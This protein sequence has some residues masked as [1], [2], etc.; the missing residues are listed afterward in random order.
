MSKDDSNW[1]MELGGMSKWAEPLIPEKI[2]EAFEEEE[3][4][5]AFEAEPNSFFD[6]HA[7]KI[8]TTFLF[9]GWVTFHFVEGYTWGQSWYFVCVTLTTVGYGDVSPSTHLG[10]ILAV[11]YIIVGLAFV[12]ESI[13]S[14]ASAIATWKAESERVKAADAEKKEAKRMKRMMSVGAMKHKK[15]R[16]KDII[17]DDSQAKILRAVGLLLLCVFI[18]AVFIATAEV[19]KCTHMI[20]KIGSTLWWMRLTW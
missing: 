17:K 5:E 2:K 8:I 3:E 9:G 16:M 10:Q 11:L 12:A 20:S 4:G 1:G 6:R 18:G 7:L 13:G 15:L 14:V 19:R